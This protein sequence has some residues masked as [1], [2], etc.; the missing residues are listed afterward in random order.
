[1]SEDWADNPEFRA[2]AKRC[3]ET[4]EP[5]V[6]G[7]HVAVSIVPPRADQVDVKLA[8]ELGYMIL[9]DKPIIAIIPPGTPVPLK[10]AKVADEIVEGDM[11]DPTMPARLRAA[12]DRVTKKQGL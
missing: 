12:V 5:M 9:L 4:L 1:M 11:R 10:L 6:K 7:S 8:V 3:R 2:Y